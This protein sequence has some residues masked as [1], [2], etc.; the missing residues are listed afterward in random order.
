M[1]ILP[2]LLIIAAMALPAAAQEGE[3]RP[4]ALNTAAVPEVMARAVDDFIVPGYRDFHASAQALSGTMAALCAAPGEGPLAAARAAFADTVAAWSHIEIVRVGP[5]IEDNRFERI[6]F[7]PDRKG[8]GL[9]QVQA[10]LADRDESATT[11]ETLRGKSVAM[12]GIGALEFL[13]HGTGNQEL[14]SAAGDYRCRY[15]TAIAGNLERLGGELVTVWEKPDGV[16]RAWK[17]PGADNPLFRTEAEVVTALLGILVHGME[18]VRDQRIETFYK[19]REA[20]TF[21]RQA[22]YWRSGLTFRSVA[23]NIK[24]I[25]ALIARSDAKQLLATDQ[26]WIMG[27]IDFLLT[28]LVNVSGQLQDAT[29]GRLETALTDGKV[30]GQLGYMLINT[31][32]VI[33]RL[34]DDFGGAIGLGAGFSFSDGD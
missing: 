16:Q 29:H 14:L 12:Q 21:P 18:T 13:L 4:P 15:G 9:R 17:Q 2:S 24:G 6:L 8:V 10:V 3:A 11:P 19:G 28:S 30:Q 5:V 20:K 31:K 27:S 26:R 34:N 22:I 32:D 33:L 7:Y 23:A 1:R 25:E